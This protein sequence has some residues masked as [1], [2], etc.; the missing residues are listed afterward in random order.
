[1]T[2]ARIGVCC[3]CSL[4]VRT[5]TVMRTVYDVLVYGTLSLCDGGWGVGSSAASNGIIL[6][7]WVTQPQ[8]GGVA[9]LTTH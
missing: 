3:G 9:L 7:P 6:A 8:A 4:V 1:M 5:Y 2:R